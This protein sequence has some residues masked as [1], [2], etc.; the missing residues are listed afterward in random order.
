MP[1][2]HARVPARLR[3]R[4]PAYP[5]ACLSTGP[6]SRLP[7]FPPAPFLPNGMATRPV[8]RVP[9][10]QGLGVSGGT[11]TPSPRRRGGSGSG[12]GG[13][14]AAHGRRRSELLPAAAVSLPAVSAPQWMDPALGTQHILMNM[15]GLAAPPRDRGGVTI[16]KQHALHELPLAPPSCAP[17]L[18]PAPLISPPA[19]RIALCEPRAPAP[20]LARSVRRVEPC[21]GLG[22]GAHTGRSGWWVRR[23]AGRCGP[24]ARRA[25]A[26][27]RC[28]PTRP[29][30]RPPR[31]RRATC[32]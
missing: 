29:G 30:C 3:A 14:G 20:K 9:F 17:P 2:P 16:I 21:V 12:G 6:H 4:L 25:P 22:V 10:V 7:T 28:V 5:P 8:V 27:L 15:G 18:P 13:G 19:S 32:V 26:T 31:V 23:T 1:W 24:G 11:D